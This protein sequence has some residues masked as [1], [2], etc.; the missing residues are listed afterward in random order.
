VTEEPQFGPGGYLPERAAKRARKIILREQ[1]GMGWPVA[2]VVAGVLLLALGA[3]YLVTRT[4]P[5]GEPY[6]A[7][8][9]LED[10]DPRGLAVLDA[11]ADQ[12]LVVRAGGGVRTFAAPPAPVV[13]C[14]ESRRLEGADGSV[15]AVNGR[16]QAGPGVSLA[17]L[18]T[19]VYDGVVYVDPTAPGPPPP[20]DPA[21]VAP[22]CAGD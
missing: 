7:V 5:P 21:R 20:P 2:A 10:V 14:E 16:V 22:M 17:P 4:G 3:V 18:P 1:M 9:D 15:W 19:L 13:Y 8:A 12:V 11:G 6:T